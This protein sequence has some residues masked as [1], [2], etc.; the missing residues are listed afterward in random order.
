M[1]SDDSLKLLGKDEIEYAMH[2]L[3]NF[4]ISSKTYEVVVHASSR[5][6]AISKLLEKKPDA[7]VLSYKTIEC[8]G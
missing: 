4:L 5:G 1:S 6:E 7:E 3:V 8:V 2:Y